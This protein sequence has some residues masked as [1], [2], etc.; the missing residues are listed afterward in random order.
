DPA[1]PAL[2]TLLGDPRDLLRTAL[3]PAGGRVEHVAARQVTWRPGRSLTVRYDASVAWPGDHVT[4][5]MLVARAGRLHPRSLVLEAGGVRVGVWRVPHDPWLPGLQAITD[6]PRLNDLLDAIEV[7]PGRAEQRIVSYRPERR[8]VVR[9]RRAGTTLFVKI[10]RPDES[11]ALHERHVALAR[12]VPVPRSLGVDPALG[13]VVLQA[14]RG[15][16]LRRRLTTAGAALPGP[17]RVLGLLDRLPRPPEDVVRPAWRAAEWATLLGRLRPHRAEA[18][19]ALAGEILD[20]ATD[21][22]APVVAVHGDLHEAQLLVR[23]GRICGLVDVDT[24]G[25]GHRLLDLANLTGHLATLSLGSAS[26]PRIER[27]ADGLLEA[28]DRAVDPVTLC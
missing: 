11:R 22:P 2:P 1:L 6:A 9:V 17:D 23:G 3:A 14:L 7:A 20:T 12:V 16:L 19:H 15:S 28:F 26:R 27:Y 5:E 8:A 18:L 24:Y 10:V 4:Q 21:R 25:L 13:V